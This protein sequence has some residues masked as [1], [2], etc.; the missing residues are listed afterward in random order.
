[1]KRRWLIFVLLLTLFTNVVKADADYKSD[2]EYLAL[3]DSMHHAFNDADSARFFVALK[4][5]EDYLLAKGD[6]HGYYT[7]RCNEIVFLMNRQKIFE[8]YKLARQLSEELREKKLDKEMYMAYNMLGHINRFCGNKEAAK[9]NFYQ[10]IKMMEEHGYYESIPPIYMNIVNVALDDDHDEAL[11]LLDK[12]MEISKKYSPERVFDIETRKT[13]SYY[14]SGDIPR[15]L[16]GYRRY[17]EGVAEGKSSVHGRS[18]EIYHLAAT[19][20]VD[21]AVELARQELGDDGHDAVTIIYE[22]AGRWK[23][24]YYSLKEQTAANDSI[25]NVV[26]TNSM[27]GIRDQLRL[28][29]VEQKTARNRIIALIIGILLLALLATALSYIVISR[30]KHM[31]E[32][33]IAYD[34][35]MEADRMKSSFIQNISHEVRTPLNIISGFTQVIANPDLEVKGEERR[36]MAKTIQKNTMLITS[37]VDEILQLSLN[38]STE[39]IEKKDEVE[40]DDLFRDLLQENQNRKSLDTRLL[41]E[42]TLN[43]DFTILTNEDLLKRIVTTLLDNAMKNTEQGTIMLKTSTSDNQLVIV[44][45]DTGCGIPAGEEEHIFD[46]FVKLDNFKEGLG[47]GLPLSRM[48]ARRLGGDVVLDTHYE[49]QGARFVVTLP[50]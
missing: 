32:L 50:R 41:Y 20:R 44:V 34:M 3:R 29:D 16:E 9:R 5:L 6:L 38:E 4:N 8:A 28:Y 39:A 25:V 49:K 11:R 45:E 46:R 21:E 40:V 36:E 47:L 1:M 13:L 27:E 10:V 30:R 24:A 14:N 23:D 33:K 19:G 43:K 22:H 7:Q 18:M 35:A 17:S 48:L 2:A 31:R 37:L 15:F 26:L 12:A 42:T